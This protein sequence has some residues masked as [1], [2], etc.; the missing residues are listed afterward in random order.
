MRREV[1]EGIRFLAGHPWLRALALSVAIGNLFGNVIDGILILHLVTER[2]FSAA[3][4]G[5]AFT[6]GSVGVIAGA[7]LAP[8]LTRRLGVGRI[9]V[10]S[11]IG[12]GLSWFPV[13]LAPDGLLFAGLATTIVALGFFR[14][15]WVVYAISLRQAVVPGAMQGRVT[16]TMRFLSWGVI[17]V[18]TTL[19]GALGGAIGLH[20]TI[21]VGAVGVMLT[22]VPVLLS[23]VPSIRTL[24]APPSPEPA[25]AQA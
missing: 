13:A 9:L 22:F 7:L 4:I 12:E 2:G 6:I 3:A 21:L 17:P 18:G 24:P 11:A 10:L 14:A 5:F 19:G 16:A 8:D 23:P 25:Q 1:A 20:E 15:F